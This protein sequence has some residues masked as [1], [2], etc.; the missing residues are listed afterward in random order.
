V[1]GDVA[2]CSLGRDAPVR[3][4]EAATLQR[5]RTPVQA[6]LLDVLGTLTRSW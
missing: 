1:P 6:A 4:I 5:L 3:H 2:V